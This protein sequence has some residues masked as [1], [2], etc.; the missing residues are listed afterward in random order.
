[1]DDII[2]ELRELN[3][4]IPT[5]L[6]L[7]EHDDLVVIQEQL[8]ISLP[9]EYKEFLLTVSDVVC[10]TIEPATVMDSQSHLHLPE[11]AA[12]AWDIG[13][14]RELI[15]ICEK[16]GDFYCIEQDGEIVFWSQ[17]ELTGEHWDSIWHW[18]TE[19]W[20]GTR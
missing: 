7:P 14:S 19:V 13:V 4:G 18:V 1:M 10:G 16:N 3:E 5:P 17:G 20:L 6:Q 15:P 8:L 9:D 11:M 2:D 12:H